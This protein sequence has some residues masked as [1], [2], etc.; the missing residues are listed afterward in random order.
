V[1]DAHIP[2]LLLFPAQTS[3]QDDPAYIA[4]KVILQDKASCFSAAVLAPP[5]SAG[6]AVL[7][8]TAAPG[9]KTSH[10][11]ALM[12]GKGTVLLSRFPPART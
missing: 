12:R 10:L 5:A 1:R 4:G 11:S 9:N 8:A 6:A 2:D 7:D 3:F